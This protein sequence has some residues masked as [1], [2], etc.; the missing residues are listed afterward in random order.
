MTELRLAHLTDPHLPF[1]LPTDYEWLS[2]R[3]LSGLSWLRKRREMHRREVAEA[4]RADLLAASPDVI[5]VTGDLVNFGL[6]REF[7]AARRWLETLGQ[8]EHVL[9]IPGNHDALAGPWQ[10]HMA[11]HWQGYTDGDARPF[12]RQHGRVALIGVSTATVTPPLMA[13][14]RVGAQAMAEVEALI[15]AARQS[16]HCPIVLMH[17][18]PT[19]IT[20]RRKGLADRTA[21]A[22]M[23]NRAGAALVL[24]GHTHLREMSFLDGADGKIPVLGLPSFSM[25]PGHHQP[26]GAW[27]MLEIAED[28]GNW[29]LTMRERG[30]DAT[31]RIVE[32]TP[33]RLTL[34][35]AA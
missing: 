25:A 14:G 23:L 26:P 21:M 10:R 35:G 13:S 27:R 6:E 17:H 7:R 15:T 29:R 33:V 30:L 28:T 16:R 9:A 8:P 20:S 12:L 24:H 19:P 1:G 31:S 5:A 18:P 22:R 3:G 32:R 11:H 34:P 4:L 2:K